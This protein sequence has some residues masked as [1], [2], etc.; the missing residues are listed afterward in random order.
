M[1]LEV[2]L[3][4]VQRQSV[5]TTTVCGIGQEVLKSIAGQEEDV[6]STKPQVAV[7]PWADVLLRLW[8]A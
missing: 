1:G 8:C 7:I 6:W 5:Y 2:Q 3:L 4:L